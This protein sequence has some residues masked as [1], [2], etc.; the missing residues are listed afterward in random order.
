VL[1]AT[2]NDKLS[3]RLLAQ[4][5]RVATVVQLRHERADRHDIFCVHAGRHVCE[6]TG[7]LDLEFLGAA[8][9]LITTPQSTFSFAA[10]ARALIKPRFGMFHG[11]SCNEGPSPEAGLIFREMEWLVDEEAISMQLGTCSRCSTALSVRKDCLFSFL[12]PEICLQA[13]DFFC[14][15]DYQNLPNADI[16]SMTSS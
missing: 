8:D 14:V 9:H 6:D 15:R 16:V 7:L 12:K 3:V 13:S 1:W 4:L 2:D 11:V 5:E 10:H